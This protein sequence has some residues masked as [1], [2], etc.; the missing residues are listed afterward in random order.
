MSNLDNI[1]EKI[2]ADA[3]NEAKVI[4]DQ[5]NR[6]KEA[7]LA[8]KKNKEKKTIIGSLRRLKKRPR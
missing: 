3:E 5:A 1:L 6:E 7:L 8:E 2:H 4:L